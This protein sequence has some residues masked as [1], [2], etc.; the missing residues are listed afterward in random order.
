MENNRLFILALGVGGEQARIK[1]YS[2]WEIKGP[3]YI[4]QI[5]RD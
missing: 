3:W 5:P 4:V 2:L 1:I